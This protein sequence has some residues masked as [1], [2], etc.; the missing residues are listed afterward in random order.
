MNI[1]GTNPDSEDGEYFRANTWAWR[2]ILELMHQLCS[3]LL[4]KK[5]LQA[6][7]VNG[8]AGP[9]NTA[10][11]QE[12]ATRFELWINDNVDGYT[13]ERDG[14]DIRSH[15]EL[16]TGAKLT[17]TPEEQTQSPYK[18]QHEHLKR[19]IEFLRHCGG[20]QVW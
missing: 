12:M 2:P 14:T 10:I 18:V 20:F 13:V 5:I 11:C 1:Y 9:Y 7:G 19:W 6:M 8:G 16:L 4:D 17:E 15:L 3:D